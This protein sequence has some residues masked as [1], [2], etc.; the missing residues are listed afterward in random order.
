[1]TSSFDFK[2]KTIKPIED[3]DDMEDEVVSDFKQKTIKPIEEGVCTSFAL[4]Q[5][6]PTTRRQLTFDDIWLERHSDDKELLNLLDRYDSEH[7]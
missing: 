5:Q 6:Q 2:Q 4:Q 1:M 7:Y 3:V